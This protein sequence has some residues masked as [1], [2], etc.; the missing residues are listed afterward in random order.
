MGDFDARFMKDEELHDLL[1]RWSVPD[2]SRSLDNRVAAAYNNLMG[3]AAERRSSALHPQRDSE[4]VKMKFCNTCQE[5]F[6]DRFSFCPVDGTPLGVAPA[7]SISEP[8]RDIETSYPVAESTVPTP[9]VSEPAYEAIPATAYRVA[10]STVPTPSVSER[11]YSAIPAS[12]AASSAAIF[13]DYHLTILED[14]GLL[15]RLAGELGGVA[16]NYQLTWPEFKR[17]PFGFVKRSIQGY[18]QMVGGFF[19]SRDI[20]IAMLFSFV[21]IAAIIGMVFVLDR[22]QSAGVSRK[23]MI[24]IAALGSLALLALFSTLL[25]RDRGADVMGTRPADSRNA[26]AGIVVSFAMVFA[27]AGGYFLFTLLFHPTN[28]AAQS[29]EDL[30]LTQM[31]TDIPNEQPTPDEGTAGMAKG[32]GG[33]SKP[34]QE[35]AG[36]GGGGGRQEKTDASNGKLPQADLRIPQVVAPD[37]HPPVIK[38]PALP[39][40]ATLEADPVLFPPDTRNLNYGDP[41]SRSTT[42]SSGPGTGNG[43]GNGTGGGVGPGSGGGYGPG[44]GGNTGGGDRREGGGGPGG[45]GGGTDYN[46]VFNGKDVT[47]KARILEKPEPQYTEAARKNQVTGTVVIKAIFSSSGQVTDIHAV[48][49]LP[50]GLTEKAIAAARQIRFIPATKD[51]HPVSMYMQLEYNFN[52]Y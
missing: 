19:G 23:G 47:S 16:H 40:P 39:M 24:I 32:N 48:S 29:A 9:S 36:G 14:R 5:Q 10:E 46:R 25:K 12:A 49:K 28:A 51:G 2:A 43:I 44:N 41:K 42:P 21:A 3:D 6:A 1:E 4:V 38:N 17:D 52:L 34:K 11:A 13:G 30:E 8:A 37:P 50:D 15:Y 31:I 26:L 20:M 33:G 45:G 22:T 35:K 27:V 18:G 7:T